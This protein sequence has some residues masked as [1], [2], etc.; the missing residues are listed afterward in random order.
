MATKGVQLWFDGRII[1]QEE[2]DSMVRELR[3]A[4][5]GATIAT[6]DTLVVRDKGHTTVYTER[7]CVW[8]RNPFLNAEVQ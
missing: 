1:G 7:Y 6:G 2:I 4:A 8:D 5:P 3:S